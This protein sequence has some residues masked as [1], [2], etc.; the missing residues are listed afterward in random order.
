MIIDLLQ[1]FVPQPWVQTLDFSTLEKVS[2]SYVSDDLRTR[3][4]D[5]IWR[6]R[7]QDTWLY[8]Y[9]LIEF[10]SSIDRYMAIR[11]MVY[12]G[13]LYQ[14]LIKSGEL[15]EDRRLPPVFPLVLYNGE[16]RWDAATELKDL[17]VSLP[18]GLEDYRPSLKYLLLD[19]GSYAHEQLVPLKNLVAA[20]FRLENARS[21]DEIVEV[22]SHLMDWLQGPEQT[23]IRR[24]FTIW[25][26]RVLLAADPDPASAESL[27]DLT[28][29]KTML[30]QRVSEWTREWEQQGWT[31]GME[32]GLEKG[33]EKGIEQGLEEGVE[34]GEKSLLIR[35]VVRRF[36]P[37]I[38]VQAQLK[39]E[40]LPSAQDLEAV[41]DWILECE[42]G[43][44]L[45]I[46]LDE[47]LGA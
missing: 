32:K 14:D 5:V 26:K 15:S 16:K 27:N 35:L 37:D 19:E 17:I 4:D 6:V 42:D 47:C 34:K 8:I 33:M 40:A 43:E 46:K 24:S 13:L 44:Q 10:Q 21:P 28:E 11:I 29:I 41:G 38:G 9:L 31:K 25:I 12:I 1:G 20:I 7:H 3:E 22:I 2:G 18:G 30:R 39:I 36:G 45:L 23:R